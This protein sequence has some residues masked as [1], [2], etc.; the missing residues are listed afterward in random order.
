LFIFCKDTIFL[1]TSQISGCFPL[2]SLLFLVP[3]ARNV[4]FFVFFFEK[5]F[6][7]SQI[8]FTFA[9]EM[10]AHVRVGTLN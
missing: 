9:P 8:L 4:V 1:D 6:A 10:P 5:N 3:F 7:V 2:I